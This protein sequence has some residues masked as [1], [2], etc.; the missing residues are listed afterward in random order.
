MW[1]VGLD[2]AFA[3]RSYFL[4]YCDYVCQLHFGF[5]CSFGS[6]APLATR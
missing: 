1:V 6:I 5:W 2:S 4:N 3:S